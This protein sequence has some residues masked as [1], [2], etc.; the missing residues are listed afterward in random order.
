[1]QLFRQLK[2]RRY[3]KINSKI[4]KNKQKCQLTKN[5]NVWRVTPKDSRDIYRQRLQRRLE[6]KDCDK[7]ECICNG[8]NKEYKRYRR[9]K[10]RHVTYSRSKCCKRHCSRAS[11]TTV[12]SYTRSSNSD[13]T[14][15]CEMDTK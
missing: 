1:M 12:S 14:N 10:K 9:I 15:T 7:E 13:I 11:D 6:E 5:R 8:A 4:R 3:K 2:S